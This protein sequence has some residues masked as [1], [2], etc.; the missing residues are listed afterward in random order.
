MLGERQTGQ[1]DTAG[2]RQTHRRT[3][4]MWEILLKGGTGGERPASGDRNRGRGE[5]E[6]YREK[7][8]EE[9]EIGRVLPVKGQGMLALHTGALCKV[10]K[11][12]GRVCQDAYVHCPR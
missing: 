11:G 12:Q 6:K 5:R 8:E 3:G 4:L 1:A 10:P 7:K 2:E 9:V